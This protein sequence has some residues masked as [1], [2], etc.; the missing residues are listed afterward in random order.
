LAS[1][2]VP[3]A[4]QITVGATLDVGNIAFIEYKQAVEESFGIES[5]HANLRHFYKDPRLPKDDIPSVS[6]ECVYAWFSCFERKME[7]LKQ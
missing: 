5:P 7:T 1:A 4:K 3:L 2:D 6:K